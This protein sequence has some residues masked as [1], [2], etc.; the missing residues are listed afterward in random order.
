MPAPRYQ[1]R[2]V[3]APNSRGNAASRA[4]RS[5]LQCDTQHLLKL[6]ML[7]ETGGNLHSSV[8]A[9][10]ALDA[11]C[12]PRKPIGAWNRRVW[13]RTAKR[14]RSNGGEKTQNRSKITLCS[15]QLSRT[16]LTLVAT[17]TSASALENW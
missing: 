14:E 1:P 15:L 5:R 11:A 9:L 2:H 17:R 13:E 3:T 10:L 8:V 6:A 4:A 16:L 7:A 12:H